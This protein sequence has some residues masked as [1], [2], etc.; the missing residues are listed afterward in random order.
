MAASLP[1]KLNVPCGA[2]AETKQYS[3]AHVHDI[4]CSLIP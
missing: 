1:R 2:G 3:T 4:I